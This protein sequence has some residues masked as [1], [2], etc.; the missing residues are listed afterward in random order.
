[1]EQPT[2]SDIE[3]P[4]PPGLASRLGGWSARAQQYPVFGK[5]WYAYRLRAF[6]APMIVFALVLALVA[7]LVPAPPPGVDTLRF[8]FTFP[9]IWLMVAIALAL[10]R[11][12]AV[13]V[14]ARGWNP[15]REAAGIVCALLLGV[16]VAWSLTPFVRTGGQPANGQASAELQAEQA[17]D[18]R[19]V[20]LA[21]WFPVLVWLAG[22]FDLAAYFRQR[23]LLREAALQAQAERYKHQRN[24]VEV[25]LAVLASQVEPHFLFN[26]LSGVRAAML[27]DPDRGILMIDHLIDYLRSTIPQLRADRASTFVALGSQCDSVRA[28]LGVIAARM[29]RLHAEVAC[30]PELRAAPIPPLM[31]ISLVENAV[32]HGIEP[33]KGPATIRVAAAC[34]EVDGMRML[35]LSVSDDGVGFCAASGSGIG[36]SNIRERLK[37]L[38][39][40]A[41]ALALRA[42]EEGG[43][44]ASITLPLLETMEEA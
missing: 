4:L 10:G 21:I 35:E 29:P 39:G 23:G 33:K 34:R 43:V 8:W 26:T 18:N 2:S 1:M 12:L 38:Y 36:L 9:A 24:E 42:R 14:R 40:G 13:L 31:L 6:R 16:L 20:N 15:R 22:P 37:H 19:I 28:Y 5:T 11:G 7:A 44:V 17:R 30:A 25:K 32:K 3:H 41:A 27:S